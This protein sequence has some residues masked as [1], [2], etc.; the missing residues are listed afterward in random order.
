MF[1]LLRAAQSVLSGRGRPRF[2]AVS[3]GARRFWGSLLC[4][5]SLSSSRKH[6][7]FL[8]F[9]LTLPGPGGG[10]DIPC[11]PPAPVASPVACISG[12]FVMRI[13]SLL[14]ACVLHLCVTTLYTT[15]QAE[16]NFAAA[17]LRSVAALYN[18]GFKGSQR[19]G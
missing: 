18:P 13:V 9:V 17:G 2:W 14:S 1:E 6:P 3:R 7:V 16:S 19:N 5:E 15:L 8:G 11:A 12:I 4:R 10:K